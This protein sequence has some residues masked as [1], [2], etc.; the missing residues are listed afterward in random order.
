MSF[1]I[2]CCSSEKEEEL[3]RKL[4]SNYNRLIRPVANNS[5][6]LDVSFGLTMSQLIDVVSTSYMLHALQIMNLTR[7]AL[8][9]RFHYIYIYIYITC[10]LW[11]KL[12]PLSLKLITTSFVWQFCAV[13]KKIETKLY[14]TYQKWKMLILLCSKSIF[15]CWSADRDKTIGWLIQDSYN[16]QM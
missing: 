14:R 13:K 2:G 5:D 9:N 4:F 12:V 6:I 3:F 15:V 11:N 7:S 10:I 16:P 8:L 1:L